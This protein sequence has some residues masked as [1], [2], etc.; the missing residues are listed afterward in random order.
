[1]LNYNKMSDLK[2][3]QSVKKLK[4]ILKKGKNNDSETVNS[5]NQD[6]DNDKIKKTYEENRK[7]SEEKEDLKKKLLTALAD[8]ENLKKTMSKDV[9]NAREYGFSRFAEQI[10]DSLD[11][12]ERTIKSIGNFDDNQL[13]KDVVDGVKMTV[14]NIENV[15][16]NNGIE[17]IMP[18]G[19]KFDHNYHQAVKT[20]KSQSNEKGTVKEVLQCGYKMK[21]RVLRPAMVT[22]CK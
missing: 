5:V 17:K 19:R 11:S 13:M 12:L 6:L 1:M 16:K 9:E 21:D 7:L 3:S 22:V 15:L 18:L 2:K 14:K 4:E 20:V 8:K 10:V